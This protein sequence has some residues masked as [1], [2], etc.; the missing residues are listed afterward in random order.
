MAPTE[1]SR[2]EGGTQQRSHISASQAAELSGADKRRTSLDVAR[3]LVLVVAFATTTPSWDRA[4]AAL[5]FSETTRTVAEQTAHAPWSGFHFLDWGFPAFIIMLAA[6]MTLSRERRSKLGEMRGQFVRRVLLRGVLLW[7]YAFFLYGGFSVPAAQ[8][9]FAHVF[10]LLS[11]CITLTG[12][13]LAFLNLRAQIV[14]F[15]LVLLANWALMTLVPVPGHGR[16]KFS[17]EGNALNYVENLLNDATM[18]T[19][20]QSEGLRHF[21]RD[22]ITLLGLAVMAYG[23][24]LF[25]LLQGQILISKF[26]IQ[27][28]VVI[29]AVTGFVAVDLSV[30][31]DSWFPINKHLWNASFVLLSGGLCYIVFAGLVQMFDVWGFR[32]LGYPLVVFGRYPLAAWTCYFLLPW[33]NFAQ[34]L[35]GPSFPPIFGVYQP[36]VIDIT[37]VALCWLLFAWWDRRRGRVDRLRQQCEQTEGRSRSQLSA[38]PERRVAQLSSLD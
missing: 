8:I 28:Q 38:E 31:W 21:H 13:S 25:G 12:L 7:I 11:M 36:L 29:L 10:F 37:Q 16:G 4:M 17:P 14:A 33:E 5:P 20:W 26:S 23:T 35:F 9:Y 22:S 2:L 1:S 15:V 18:Q 30:L 24:C 32:R 6:S 34:R 27:R 19:S 3:G